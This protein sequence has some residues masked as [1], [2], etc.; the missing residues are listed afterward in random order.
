[1]KNHSVQLI[2]SVFLWVLLPESGLGQ[3]FNRIL[4]ADF[5]HK[6]S[7]GFSQLSFE[8][9]SLFPL[10]LQNYRVPTVASEFGFTN[11]YHS[12]KE[13]SFHHKVTDESRWLAFA[14]PFEYKN[15]AR[16]VLGGG[17]KKEDFQLKIEE[18]NEELRLSDFRA[19]SEDFA[20]AGTARFER[21]E[22][23]VSLRHRQTDVASG[24]WFSFA[25][26]LKLPW[27]TSLSYTE[28]QTGFSE[29]LILQ[30]SDQQVALPLDI[31][32]H[33]QQMQLRSNPI[34]QI[35]FCA[36]VE[37][38]DLSKG[39][40]PSQRSNYAFVASGY[41]SKQM[42]DFGFHLAKN[43][44]LYLRYSALRLRASADVFYDETKFGKITALEFDAEAYH[45]SAD[46]EAW[47]RHVFGV[48]GEH[49]FWKAYVRARVETWP[50]TETLIDLL[51]IR[52][53]GQ[54]KA[55]VPF[56]K[57]FIAYEYRTNPKFLAKIELFDI[58]PD[59]FAQTWRPEFLVFGITD[60]K[61]HVLSVDRILA[62]QISL[63]AAYAFSQL[64][65]SY[66]ISQLIPIHT[67]KQTESSELPEPEPS[68]TPTVKSASTKTSGGTFHLLRL[69]YKFD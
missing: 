20:M 3:G 22:L 27:R 51:G 48:G 2:L 39:E 57:Y 32:L 15:S 36:T 50:F 52:L 37:M 61:N 31:E 21:V 25:V 5:S 17:Y 46:Y 63:G 42:I 62:M 30:T 35:D 7:L 65:L 28:S 60:L 69:D 38:N 64:E 16:F 56:E 44:Q 19:A 58:R 40:I 12:R 8:Q 54:V 67:Q 49:H 53:L 66:R 68:P 18:P 9:V 11:F 33:R 23:G 47:Q 45:I 10:V 59:G 55:E 24:A 29:R 34:A 43:L 26:G 13:D 41:F 1:M 4:P 14:L 6:D